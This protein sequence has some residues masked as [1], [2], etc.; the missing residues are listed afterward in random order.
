MRRFL[1]V[2]LV[3]L[4]C[5]SKDDEPSSGTV[6]SSTSDATTSGSTSTGGDTTE[7]S[8]PSESSGPTTGDTGTTGDTTG[9]STTDGSDAVCVPFCDRMFECGLDGAFRGCPCEVTGPTCA[10]EWEKTTQCFETATCSE[11]Q[12][13]AHPCWELFA[14]A[15]DQC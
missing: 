14:A 1:S 7:T 9:G 13:E 6:S 2:V 4:G 15:L 8:G 5:E 12:D 11:L 10:A 3:A